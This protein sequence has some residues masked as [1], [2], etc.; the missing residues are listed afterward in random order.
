[1]EPQSIFELT[2]NNAGD[3]AGSSGVIDPT[4]IKNGDDLPLSDF[5]SR[6]IRIAT[7]NWSTSAFNS[8]IDPWLAFFSQD[9]IINKLATY[10]TISGTLNVKVILNGNAFYFGSLVMSYM[11]YNLDNQLWYDDNGGDYS[12]MLAETSRPHVFL[13]PTLSEPV[14]MKLPFF[15][16][17]D[18]VDIT[19]IGTGG[20][21]PNLGL[22]RLRE[23]VSLKHATQVLTLSDTVPITLYA[24]M[25]NVSVEGATDINSPF[26]TPQSEMDEG[27]KKPLSQAATAVKNTADLLTDIPAIGGY[28]KA[29]SKA[30]GAAANIF[31]RL[32]MSKPN[33][34]E[35]SKKVVPS[36]NGMSNTNTTYDGKR[37][38][39]DC[40]NEL[41]ISPTIAGLEPEDP[42]AILNIAKHE[43]VIDMITWTTSATV[44]DGLKKFFVQP[45]FFRSSSTDTWQVAPLT[46]AALPFRYWT[47]CLKFRFRVIASAHHRGRLMIRY[48]PTK[49]TSGLL[50]LNT[51]YCH[52]IDI[53]EAREFE[54][55]IPNYQ[56]RTWLEMA[57]PALGA[58]INPGSRFVVMNTDLDYVMPTYGNGELGV[59]VES[60]L[61]TP[62]VDPLVNNDIRIIVSVCAGDDFRVTEPISQWNEYAYEM[63]SAIDLDGDSK[64]A[65]DLGECD[66][67]D[68]DLVYIGESIDSFRS[69]FK[70]MTFN[71]SYMV[72]GSTS[73][74]PKWTTTVIPGLPLPRGYAA[75]AVG[76]MAYNYSRSHI[77]TYITSAFAGF[78]GSTRIRLALTQLLDTSAN[79]RP[80]EY[81]AV[82]VY[83]TPGASPTSGGTTWSL[84]ND[85]TRH[86]REY[87]QPFK[88]IQV[89]S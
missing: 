78:R 11:P 70:R 28:A 82:N 34:V 25:E 16:E 21:H 46:G 53:A 75:L 26:M 6:P 30:A 13:D 89:Q 66:Q 42:L 63:Q 52:E 20:T 58:S 3:T 67:K 84:Q 51:A 9:R 41:S 79:Y 55:S 69:L 7:Y 49:L 1:M 48:D 38:T 18:K 33:D 23:L 14:E 86:A 88:P 87:V 29:T 32:G 40:R 27:T 62:S 65:F 12:W 61:T 8:T 77:L 54:V 72:E 80:T 59:Y 2:V 44:G 17:H 35:E 60:K 74:S 22:L 50:S 10:K 47:G 37:M 43:C 73:G 39:V 45:G 81:T 24:W 4:R 31:D 76:S 15:C 19:Q 57:R 85:P 56:N 36:L 71:Y 83:R 64:V 5:L 68:N